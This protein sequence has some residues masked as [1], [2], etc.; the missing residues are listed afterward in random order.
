[1]KLVY[2][3]DKFSIWSYAHNGLDWVWLELIVSEKSDQSLNKVC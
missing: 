2:Y 3:S 1:M